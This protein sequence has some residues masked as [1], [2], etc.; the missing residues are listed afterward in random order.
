MLDMAKALDRIEWTYLEEVLHKYGFDDKWIRWVMACITTVSFATVINGEKG[1]LFSPSRG[2]WQGC[3][4][5]PYLFIHCAEGFHYLIQKAIGEGALY[6]IKMGSSSSWAWRSIVAGR[7]ILRRGWRWNVDNGSSID[8]WRDPWLPRS[9][10]FKVL[11]PPPPP[12]APFS[13]LR[14]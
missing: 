8:I 4:L 6:G 10:S 14:L 12:D 7:A 13:S 3:P 9:L 11:S 2:I 5:S 1:D